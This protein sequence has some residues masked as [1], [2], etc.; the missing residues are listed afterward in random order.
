MTNIEIA[1]RYRSDIKNACTIIISNTEL[2]QKHSGEIVWELLEQIPLWASWDIKVINHIV[3]IA[4]T[5]FMLPSIRLWLESDRIEVVRSTIGKEVYEY[6]INYTHINT[7]HLSIDDVVDIEKML[8]STG[9][10][11][12]LST[13]HESV[14]PW[15]SQ[16]LPTAQRVINKDIALELFKHT[17]YVYDVT[18]NLDQSEKNT[19]MGEL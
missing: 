1:R 9:A 7:L 19:Q 3:N 6:L 15:I 4:G 10:S 8:Q 16:L 17:L 18:N 2:V 5:V 12:L 11:V 13:V 14:R